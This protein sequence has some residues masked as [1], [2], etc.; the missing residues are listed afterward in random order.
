MKRFLKYLLITLIVTTV[1][2]CCFSMYIGNFMFNYVLNPHYENNISTKIKSNEQVTINNQQW[3]NHNSI[4]ISI[5]S[6]DQLT[7]NAYYIKNNSHNYMILV[8]G[9]MSSAASM[10]SPAKRMMK[11]NFQLIIPDLRGHGLSEGDYIGMGWVDKNDIMKWIE[12]ITLK[13]S[14]A[15]IVLYGISMGGSAVMNVAGENPKNVKAV[16]EDCGFTSACDIF[17]SQLKE[18]G[19]M[20][21]FILYTSTFMT[22]LRA[23]YN[24]KEASSIN[25]VKKTNIPI[26]FIHGSSD[27]FVPL[28]MMY[29]LY[30]NTSSPKEKLVIENAGHADCNGTNARLYYSTIENFLKKYL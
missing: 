8:H 5:Q 14:Q 20:E 12:Y 24:L 29:E 13:D 4:K 26:L 18:Y 23:G 30:E 19:K 15:S 21:N 2:L 9:F 10:V 16:I 28:S 17:S 1:F 7:L 27:D 3:L 22:Y 25:Q 6:E 11:N